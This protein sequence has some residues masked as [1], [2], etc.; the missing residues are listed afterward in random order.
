VNV[1]DK[2]K[3]LEEEIRKIEKR[4]SLLEEEMPTSKRER[5]IRDATLSLLEKVLDDLRKQH[6]SLAQRDQEE[7][8]DR[9]AG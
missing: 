1:S 2:I 8:T 5:K 6:K 7:D 4:A 9:G 3:A